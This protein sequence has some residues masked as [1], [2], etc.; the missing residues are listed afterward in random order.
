M[1]YRMLT[2]DELK[3]LEEDL[4]HFLIVN[5]VH[6]TEWERLNREQPETATKLVELFSDSVLQKVYE[7]IRFLEFRSKE[8]CLVFHLEKDAIDMISIQCKSGTEGDLSTAESI[9]ET[10]LKYSGNL[11][12]FRAAK[13]YKETRELEIHRMVEQGCVLS[14]EEFWTGLVKSLDQ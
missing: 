14:T 5:G 4:K 3:P 9:H 10:I 11:N 8:S 6:D 1:K 13:P 7:K 12:W 2:L